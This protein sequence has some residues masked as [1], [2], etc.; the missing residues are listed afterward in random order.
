MSEQ[1]AD[2]WDVAT[3]LVHAGERAAAPSATPTTTP[4][5]TSTT[6]VSSNFDALDAAFETNTG[7]VYTR[8]G[9]PTVA[10]FEH[11]VAVAEGG[12]GAVAFGSGMAALYAGIL[13]AG[14]PRGETAPRPRAILAARELYGSTTVLL[15]DFFR[16]AGRPRGVL[17]YVRF[18]SSGRRAG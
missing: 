17:R 15:H 18:G 7:Y 5:Y 16:G 10:A 1:H 9:N 11:A 6:Y 12:C 2:G 14:T 13:A 3:R 4:I 8:Y